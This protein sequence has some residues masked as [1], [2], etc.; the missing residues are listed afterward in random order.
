[1]A[2]PR[3]RL[4]H[5]EI[6]VIPEPCTASIEASADENLMLRD[7]VIFDYSDRFLAWISHTN[8]HIG[9]ANQRKLLCRNDFT[10]VR[11]ESRCRRSVARN[12]LILEP[13]KVAV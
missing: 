1:M 8:E 11:G 3:R 13:W 9:P 4:A 2:C 7:S 5:A 10:Q 12:R 6:A